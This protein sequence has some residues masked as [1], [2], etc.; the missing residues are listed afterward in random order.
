[1]LPLN[2]ESWKVITLVAVVLAAATAIWGS[3]GTERGPLR[4]QWGRYVDALNRRLRR[5]HQPRSGATF[6]IAQILAAFFLVGTSCILE[7]PVLLVGLPLIAGVPYVVLEKR[8]RDRVAKLDHQADG[9]CLA[10]ANALKAT[11]SIG[12]AFET[13]TAL[14]TGPVQEEMS[15]ANKETKLGLPIHEAIRAASGRA[16]SIKLATV[17]AA[18]LIG[19]QIGGNLTRVLETTAATLRELERL[20]GVVRQKTAEGRMQLWG[21]SLIPPMI[22]Y[23]IHKLDPSFFVPLHATFVGKMCLFIAV[24]LYIVGVAAARKVLMVDV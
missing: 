23:A 9:F 15:L 24:I 21:L 6:G 2:A 22:I 13:T 5:L 10:L 1:M 19:R 20:E 17:L 3:V 18:V 11:P 12:A 4:V 8:L 14:M 7:M 16:G